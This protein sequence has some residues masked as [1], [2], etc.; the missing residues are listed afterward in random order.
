MKR[1]IATTLTAGL[2]FAGCS[3]E[4]TQPHDS[5]TDYELLSENNH[6]SFIYEGGYAQLAPETGSSETHHIVAEFPS[7]HKRPGFFEKDVKALSP[8]AQRVIVRTSVAEAKNLQNAFACD[9]L[10]IAESDWGG[11][12]YVAALAIGNKDTDAFAVWPPG[13]DKLVVCFRDGRH[14]DDGILLATPEV[15]R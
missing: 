5:Q 12:R 14:P 7:R 1:V 11:R 13:E 15:S 3:S 6:T 8:M 9:E 10:E 2:M 4:P